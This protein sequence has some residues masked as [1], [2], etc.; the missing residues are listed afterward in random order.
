MSIF[1][2]SH[3][4]FLFIVKFN[5]INHYRFLSFSIR[6]TGSDCLLK[7]FY[8]IKVPKFLLFISIDVVLFQD[9][10]L[11]CQEIS[12]IKTHSFSLDP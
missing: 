4:N 11:N 8:T 9:F 2:F 6:Q 5:F 1:F 7:Y 3:F 12:R 10:L